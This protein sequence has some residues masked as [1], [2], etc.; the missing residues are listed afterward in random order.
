MLAPVAGFVVLE[1]VICGFACWVGSRTSARMQSLTARTVSAACVLALSS[2]ALTVFTAPFPAAPFLPSDA[3]H[4]IH[5]TGLFD[6]LKPNVR[7]SSALDQRCVAQLVASHQHW[8]DVEQRYRNLTVVGS[9]NARPDVIV[10]VVESFRHDAVSATAAPNLSR[11]AAESV[12]AQQH[13]SSGNATH[14]G[15]FGLLYGLNALWYPRAVQHQ[16]APALPPLMAQLGYRSVFLGSWAIERWRGMDQFLS[17]KHFDHFEIIPLG[18]SYVEG[19]RTVLAR[20]ARMLARDGEFSGLRDKPLFIVLQI[21]TTHFEFHCEP[22]DEIFLPA[23]AK[24]PPWDESEMR[25]AANRYANSVH[26]MDRL[27][28]PLLDPERVL[29]IVG[30]HGESLGEDGRFLHCSALSQAQIQTPFVFHSPGIAPKRIDSPTSHMDL[31]PTLLDSLGVAVSEPAVL[32]GRNLLRSTFDQRSAALVL[33]GNYRVTWAVFD[34]GATPDAATWYQFSGEPFSASFQLEGRA[35]PV[36]GTVVP[37]PVDES[38]FAAV[39]QRMVDQLCADPGPPLPADPVQSLLE[40]SRHSDN[41][42]RQ[43]AILK[44]AEMGP[45]AVRT[46]PELRR[47]L[48]DTD[49]QI[50]AAAA[51]TLSVIKDFE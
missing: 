19:D 5:L 33:G 20:A 30:D 10:F 44:L 23:A 1:S 13:Y 34:A 18:D 26:C 17:D 35:S 36:D 9:P 40:F 29:I 37:E 49:P 7:P 8:D 16:L 47:L 41:R 15:Y 11:L 4:P 31:I 43:L 46:V 3:P 32:H 12:V 28:G 50:R 2:S 48:N 25:L 21:N 38:H 27:I 45:G 24:I 39:F 14:L 22:E 6:K 42:V 51:K